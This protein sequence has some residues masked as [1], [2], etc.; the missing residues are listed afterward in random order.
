MERVLAV[1]ERKHELGAALDNPRAVDG[2][3]EQ[4]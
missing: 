2:V 1:G 4:A 3:S